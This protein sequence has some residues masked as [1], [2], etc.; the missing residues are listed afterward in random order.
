MT[1]RRPAP[2][3][4][5]TRRGARTASRSGPEQQTPP[6]DAAA[7][8]TGPDSSTDRTDRG[9]QPPE[10]TVLRL[11]GID[12]MAVPAHAISLALV[13]LL[14][15]V[16]VF[17][18]L[19]GYLSQ[20]ARYDAVV[21]EIAD[22]RATSSALEEEAA[23][24]QDEDYV[25]SQA[26]ERLSYVMPGETTYVVVGADRFRNDAASSATSADASEHRPWYEVVRESA[27]VAGGA[28][29]SSEPAADPAQRSRATTPPPASAP[30]GA[31]AAPAPAP[32]GSSRTSGAT[33]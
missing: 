32:T 31:S 13:L 27:R 29:Q 17:P 3:R 20:R 4:P 14:A 19:R 25:R 5:G 30:S 26:R 11:G 24:W 8:P 28:E 9:G 15:F 33:P 18:S 21:N 7:P 1:P 12:G 23:R 6:P 2:A 16:V 22:A 10:R